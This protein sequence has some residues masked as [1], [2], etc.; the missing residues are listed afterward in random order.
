[1]VVD[2]DPAVAH[3]QEQGA[4]VLDGEPAD[5]WAVVDEF[6]CFRVRVVPV[7]PPLVVVHP[8]ETLLL[9]VPERPLADGTG[10]VRG[11]LRLRGRR[12]SNGRQIGCHAPNETV[13]AVSDT[14]VHRESESHTALYPPVT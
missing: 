8:V 14:G 6:V 7:D 3:E 5:R 13:F 4:V 12:Y 9:G 11:Y 10:Y 1:M 2:L